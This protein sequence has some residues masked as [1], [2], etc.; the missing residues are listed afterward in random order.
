MLSIEAAEVEARRSTGLEN[1]GSGSWRKGLEVLLTSVEAEADLNPAGRK[2]LQSEMVAQLVNRLEIEDWIERHPEVLEEDIDAPIILATLPRTGQTAAGWILDR[3][4][5]NRSLYTYLA[6]RPVPP[7]L[8]DTGS[9]LLDP[10]IAA[11]RESV[12][13]LPEEVR[14]MHLNDADEPDECHWLTS[15]TF[16]GAHQIYSM[17]VPSFY[18]WSVNEADMS[19]AYAYYRVQLQLLQSKTPGTRWVLK[20]SPHL[21]HLEELHAAL[22]SARFVQF[23]RSPRSVIASNC[24]LTLQLRA[25]R[26]ERV[27]PREI[28]DSVLQLLGD[29]I[30]RSLRFRD[31]A[32]S[33][34][35]VDVDFESFVGDPMET[36]RRIY[37]ELG[38][39]LPSSASAPMQAWVDENPRSA[40]RPSLNLERFGLGEERIREALAP[41]CDRF[42]VEL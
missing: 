1:F 31:R 39:E 20:N 12:E 37:D 19:E 14:R 22:P 11:A 4:P 32:G 35:W 42:G 21:L 27:D 30:D 38:I 3:D 6:K 8:S 33:P 9:D 28:G 34:D 15:N 16:R 41:Y 26:S 23:H 13:S 29:Y 5:R 2:I 24:E 7:P 10:R 18:D 17:R 25:M 36:V 40:R